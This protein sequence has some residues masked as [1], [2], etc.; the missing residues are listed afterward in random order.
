MVFY[1]KAVLEN[2]DNLIMNKTIYLLAILILFQSCY[3]YKTFDIKYY[4]TL[5]PK[6]VKIELLNATKLKGQIIDFNKDTMTVK[7]INETIKIPVLDIKTIKKREFS[8]LKSYLF[9]A[10]ISF[11]LLVLLFNELTKTIGEAA[12]HGIK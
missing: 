9:G 11:A 10:T 7:K 8:F 2:I 6:K 4:N 12:V 1:L 3:T 5:R